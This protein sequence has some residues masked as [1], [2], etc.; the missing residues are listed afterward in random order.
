ML[1]I[2]KGEQMRIAIC[3][4]DPEFRQTISGFLKP[5]RSIYP[6]LTESEFG[7]GEELVKA[8]SRRQ[9]FDILFLDIKMKDVDGIQAAQKIRASDIDVIII[10]VTSY[11][12]FVPDTFRVGAFQFLLKPVSESDFKRDFERAADYF[13]ISHFKYRIRWKETTVALEVKDIY[14]IEAANRHLLVF[15]AE[16]KFECVGRIAEEEKKLTGYN[17][18]KCHQSYMVNLSYVRQID[19]S[20]VYLANGK[21]IPVSRKHKERIKDAFNSYLSGC[22]V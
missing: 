21:Q 19:N 15:T 14:Y 2:K 20:K 12:E 17:I 13:R 1:F 22:S 7:S 4:D 3:D 8:Y 18:V 11:T 5:Y 9:S 10:F 6:E 16:S